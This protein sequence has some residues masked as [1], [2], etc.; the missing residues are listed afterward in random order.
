MK[1][2]SKIFHL[3]PATLFC[4]PPKKHKKFKNCLFVCL[5]ISLKICLL[6]CGLCFMLFVFDNVC[7]R[8]TEILLKLIK[9][10][11]WKFDIFR[12][13]FLWNK[14]CWWKISVK[15]FC[16]GFGN[17]KAWNIPFINKRILLFLYVWGSEKKLRKRIF[18]NH[19]N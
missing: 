13:F 11:W 4:H 6:V 19:G 2:K 10:C 12:F 16:W 14:F 18:K 5:K 17:W 7:K 8:H 3:I 9:N 1:N 15:L